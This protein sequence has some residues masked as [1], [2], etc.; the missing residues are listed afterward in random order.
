MKDS[1]AKAFAIGLGV[2]V[3]AV[4]AIMFMQRGAHIDLPGTIMVRTVGT[5]DDES[6]AVVNLHISNPSDYT[7]E[8]H[9]VT[10]TVETDH[11][12]VTREIVSKSDAKRLFESMPHNGPYYAPLYT[13]APIAPHTSG[14]YTV[15][16]SFSMPERMLK[17]RK[18]FVLKLVE[19]NGTVVEYSVK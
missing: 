11:G 14:D 2:V 16:A 15:A 5:S 3:V 19:T 1:F 12:D 4:A 13:N 10:M 9:N 17:D 18:R 6:L 7:F 8:V